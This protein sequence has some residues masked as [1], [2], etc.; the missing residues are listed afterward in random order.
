[1]KYMILVCFTAVITQSHGQTIVGT[2]Q[3]SDEKTC[4]QSGM[5]ESD[6]EKELLSQMGGSS[7]SSVARLIS[8]DAKG[9][10]QEGVFS[11]GKKKGTN[12]NSF[13]YKINGQELLLLD[14]KS[15]IMTQQLIIDTLVQSTLK[16]HDSKK[17]CET[18]TFTRIK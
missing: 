6:T 16:F 14:A 13:K 18:K 3:L 15:G 12:M 8:F 17:D 5:K 2:W 10:G 11:S 1:M 4:F 7:Q 9:R